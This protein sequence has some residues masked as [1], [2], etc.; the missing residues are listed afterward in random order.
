MTCCSKI[1]DKSTKSG[2]TYYKCNHCGKSVC[3]PCH[4]KHLIT[5]EQRNVRRKEQEQLML[6]QSGL[7]DPKTSDR[8][9][10]YFCKPCKK[11]ICKVCYSNHCLLSKSHQEKHVGFD[12]R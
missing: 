6:C 4:K 9:T 12:I 8:T 1:H 10:I 7:H 2:V 5:C 11:S 3:K